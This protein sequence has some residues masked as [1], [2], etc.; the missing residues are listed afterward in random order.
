MGLGGGSW[1][2]G[3]GAATA[4]TLPEAEREREGEIPL[5]PPLPPSH[6][7]PMLSLAEPSWRPVCGGAWE[8]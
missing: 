3:R 8:M 6:L 2:Q 4:K 5:N 7:L 1:S